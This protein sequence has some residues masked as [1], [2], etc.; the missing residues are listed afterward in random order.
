MVGT[1]PIDDMSPVSKFLIDTMMKEMKLVIA[2]K[3][4]FEKR[5]ESKLLTLF[6]LCRLSGFQLTKLTVL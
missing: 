2:E 4:G 1:F 6:G 5:F 3:F